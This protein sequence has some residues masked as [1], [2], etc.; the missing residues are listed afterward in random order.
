MRYFA[1]TMIFLIGCFLGASAEALQT[2]NHASSDKLIF[3][4]LDEPGGTPLGLNQVVALTDYIERILPVTIEVS[5]LTRRE[6]FKEW[7]LPEGQ[8]DLTLLPKDV[9]ETKLRERYEPLVLMQL[10]GK[11]EKEEFAILVG[12]PGLEKAYDRIKETLL[13]MMRSGDGQGLLT[14]LGIESLSDPG[15]SGR[16]DRSPVMN[17]TGEISSPREE[18]KVPQEA[19][20]SE[21]QTDFTRNSEV[22]DRLD[23]EEIIDL[24]GED[25]VAPI[26]AQPDIPQNLRPPGVPVVR[27]GRAQSQNSVVDEAPLLSS[28]PTTIPRKEPKVVPELL[29]EPEPEPNVVYI[30]PFGSVMVP[31][32]VNAHLFDQFVDL[33]INKESQ[34]GLQF[35]IL[36]GGLERVDSLWLEKRK[37]ITGELYAYVEESGCCS[38]DIRAKARIT[39]KR[40]Y[41]NAP[42]FGFEFPVSVFFDHDVSTLEQERM[43]LADE[44]ASEL[45]QELFKALKN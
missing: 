9:V 5:R 22:V 34:L 2:D 25:S 31:K 6:F 44:I 26:V 19:V 41:S 1:F 18:G 20:F 11:E 14:G 21:N 36:K 39:Y 15:A 32:E 16:I 38:T 13:S 12:K 8:A 10:S 33:M 40:P 43:K 27:P 42:V 45:S 29:P 24:L 3:I 28:L 37:Y 23:Q 30:V 35:V 4:V 17:Q 7:F